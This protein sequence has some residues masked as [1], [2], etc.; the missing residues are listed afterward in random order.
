MKPFT[1]NHVVVQQLVFKSIYSFTCVHVRVKNAKVESS[2]NFGFLTNTLK[3]S[4]II[5]L[6]VKIY[7]AE[8]FNLQIMKSIHPYKIQ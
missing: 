3:F 8:I 7:F 6:T 4:G 5:T 2:L 1:L